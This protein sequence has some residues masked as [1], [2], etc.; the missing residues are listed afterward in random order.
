MSLFEKIEEFEFFG[1][2]KSEEKN[3]KNGFEPKGILLLEENQKLEELIQKQSEK[4]SQLK[5]EVKNT[6]NKI[7][8]PLFGLDALSGQISASFSEL[9]KQIDELREMIEESQKQDLKREMFVELKKESERFRDDWHFSQQKRAIE[10][11]IQLYDDLQFLDKDHELSAW[12]EQIIY[13]LRDHG[14]E[15]IKERPEHLDTNFQEAV[16]AEVTTCPDEDMKVVEVKK[17]GF[18]YRDG[19]VIRPMKVKVKSYKEENN[20]KKFRNGRN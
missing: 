10:R 13:L 11:S 18:R 17:E 4:L 19:R 7:Q 6:K 8:E 1:A 15:R 3:G 5:R 12:K 9:Q 14:L 20:A 16:E 2:E